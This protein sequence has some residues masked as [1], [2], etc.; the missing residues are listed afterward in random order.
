[1]LKAY[2]YSDK[3]MPP[4]SED[5]KKLFQQEKKIA[6]E[7]VVSNHNQNCDTTCPVC[8]SR[9]TKFI[10]E[11]WD[12]DYQFCEECNSIFVP[13]RE[14]ILQE[15]LELPAMKEL[16]N[17]SE[18]QKYAQTRRTDIWQD[19][20]MWAEFRSYRY[21]GRNKGLDVIDVGNKY[22]GF[23]ALIQQ[24]ALSGRYELRDSIL[25]LETEKVEQADI[26]FY[27][28]QLQ[29]EI[30]PISTLQGI[31]DSLK[32]DGLLFLNT[33]L[34]SG[35]DILTLKGGTDDIFPYEHVMLPS[36]KG[37]Q[38]ILEQAGFELLEITTPGTRDMDAVL[39][40]QQ[41]IEESNFFVK[42]LLNNADKATLA[43]FQQFLQK[44]GM[45]SFAQVVARKRK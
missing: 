40:N 23:I 5:E 13:L 11:R 31:R 35:F 42:Y 10:F 16:R 24:S 2:D 12:I 18:Y 21:L 7:F 4:R 41:R 20:I 6:Q 1:M 8:K 25:N 30:D 45:T 36:K 19:V 38:M 27:M 15:Y 37:L 29:H 22:S 14:D 3:K 43:D 44:S 9:N 17:S 33:R 28:N 26:M 34:G 39:A 32:D